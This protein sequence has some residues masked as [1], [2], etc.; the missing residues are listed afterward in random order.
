M[1]QSETTQR[2]LDVPDDHPFA[3]AAL[4]SDHLYEAAWRMPEDVERLLREAT[5]DGYT[6]NVCAGKLDVG[7]VLVDADPQLPH[8]I[9]ADMDTLPF[10]DS[11]FDYVLLD[12]PWKLNYYKRQMPFFEAV[13][14][15][16]PDGLILANWLWIGESENTRIDGPLLIRADDAWANIS[17]IVPHR[18]QPAQADLT[19]WGAGNDAVPTRP[20]PLKWTECAN[21]GSTVRKT[22]AYES[23]SLFPSTFCSAEHMHEVEHHFGEP[24]TPVDEPTEYYVP[25]PKRGDSP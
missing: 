25:G 13:R 14:V 17:V 23:E 12:P 22:D 5:A 1:S 19:E 8:A 11:T 7:D 21:C 9:P 20:N 24:L 10:E 18:K 4:D 16:K 6:L 3:G 2:R 15:T